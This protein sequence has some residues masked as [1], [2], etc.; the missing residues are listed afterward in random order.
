MHAHS[1]TRRPSGDSASAASTTWRAAALDAPPCRQG[2]LLKC[3]GTGR[4][5]GWRRVWVVLTGDRLYY[6]PPGVYVPLDRVPVRPL[7]HRSAPER[8]TFSRPMRLLQPEFGVAA[9][10]DECVCVCAL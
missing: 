1:T 9:I 2:W 6:T 5:I 8:A 3:T 4:H 10:R 7:P